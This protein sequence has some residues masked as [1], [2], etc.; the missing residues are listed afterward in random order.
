M[1]K[2]RLSMLLALFALLPPASASA[3]LWE[4]QAQIEQRLGVPI[5][6]TG[7]PNDRVFTYAFEGLEVDVK[8]FAGLSDEETYRHPDET[9]DFTNSELQR[10][11]KLN[12]S[13]ES[14]RDDERINSWAI[15]AANGRA[16]AAYFPDFDHKRLYFY[17]DD[18]VKRMLD[19]ATWSRPSRTS[20]EESFEGVLAL[21]REEKVVYLVVRG[22]KLVIE[23]PWAADGYP[24]RASLISGRTYSITIRDE[25][26]FDR[27]T[28][29]AFV[30]DRDHKDF[31]DLFHDSKRYLVQR[32]QDGDKVVFD[33]SICE[34]HH[35][36]MIEKMGIIEYGLRATPP[37]EGECEEDAFLHLIRRQKHRFSF[38]RNASS[39]AGE[40]IFNFEP[41]PRGAEA[42]HSALP[43]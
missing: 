14:W 41:A 42:M 32:I 36:K 28:V 6:T 40:L 8:F 38:A 21:R 15:D 20:K 39:L 34:L 33:R 13:G 29:V 35:V 12:S 31:D 22:R 24:A 10:L 16:Y 18:S 30:S 43:K 9:V 5:K 7:Y 19:P 17:T 25:E 37:E 27:D 26:E 4:T 23:I 11:L 2:C 3:Y 1:N